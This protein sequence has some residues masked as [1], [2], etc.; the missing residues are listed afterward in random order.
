MCRTRLP[1]VGVFTDKYLVFREPHLV[2]I[3]I[4]NG[5]KIY[6]GLGPREASKSHLS[7]CY[8]CIACI[9]RDYDYNL[10]IAMRESMITT[11]DI[12]SYLF[13]GSTCP[14]GYEVVP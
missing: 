7:S 11:R 1:P 14:T 10:A 8:S 3:T 2:R 6:I 9:R 12:A 5:D 13:L 4:T